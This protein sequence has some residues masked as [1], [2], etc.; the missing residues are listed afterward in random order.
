LVNDVLDLS[1]VEAGRMALSKSSA[2]VDDIVVAAVEAVRPLFQ[3]KGLSLDSTITAGLPP[4]FCDSTRVRQVL[5]NLLSNAGRFTER[6]GVH[7]RVARN[8]STVVFSVSDT[9]PGITPEDQQRIF[10]PFQQLDTSIRR[11]HGGSGLGLSISRRL[12]EMHGGRMWLESE[13]GVGTTI[14]FSLPLDTYILEARSTGDAMRWFSPYSEY[15]YRMRTRRSKAPAPTLVPRYVLLDTGDTLQR[16][17]TR[18]LDGAQTVLVRDIQEAVDELSRSPA[19]ALVV[20]SPPFGEGSIPVEDLTS[21]PFGTPVAT[22][23]VPG[24]DEAAR[25]LNV[26]RYLVKPVTSDTILSTLDG[27][28]IDIERIL[29]VDDEREVLRLF[30]RML[31]AADRGYRVMW[32]TNGPRA[33]ALM[34]ERRPDVVLLDLIMP[35]MDGFQVLQEK[36]QNAPIR[37]IPVVVVSSRDPSGEPIMSE[38]LTV[39]RGGGLSARDLLV[40]IETVSAALSPS[41][42]S[43]DPAQRGRNHD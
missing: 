5:I 35:E 42:Q 25:K 23:W 40:C 33:L 43:D 14:S 22:C 39:T 2:K 32:A 30:S 18:Y 20:N 24:D 19:Q 3:S 29:L 4:L 16:L 12:V 17:C 7:I 21:L 10:E 31:A 1:Q 27:L 41:A 37:D 8:G 26:M 11:R 34:Q 15:E 9:G 38:L 36:S 13:S 6:G 28:G